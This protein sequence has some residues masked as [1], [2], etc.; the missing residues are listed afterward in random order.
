MEEYQNNM[1]MPNPNTEE[2]QSN[3]ASQ[4]SG[5]LSRMHKRLKPGVLSAVCERRVRG[6][7]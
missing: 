1:V 3:M 4:I 6:Y 5:K 7:M 2:Y